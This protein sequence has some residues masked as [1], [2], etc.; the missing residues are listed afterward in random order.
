M[1]RRVLVV[2]DDEVMLQLVREIL[3]DEGYTVF[4]SPEPLLDPA[5]L[6]HLSPDV[7]VLDIYF[8]GQPLGGQMLLNLRHSHSHSRIPVILCSGAA[9]RQELGHYLN[10]QGVAVLRKPFRAED[11][12]SAVERAITQPLIAP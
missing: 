1:S 12:V 10:A 3:E 4:T 5:A 2:D 11:L 9:I 6:D 7:I 8:I